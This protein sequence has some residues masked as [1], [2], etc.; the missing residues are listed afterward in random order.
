MLRR[1]NRAYKDGSASA[2]S[3]VAK[4]KR[5]TLHRTL[6]RW[7]DHLGK[8]QTLILRSDLIFE[9]KTHS[10][11]FTE[12]LAAWRKTQADTGTAEKARAFFV[13]RLAIRV[14]RERLAVKRQSAAIERRRL[15]DLKIVFDGELVALSTVNAETKS[16]WRQMTRQ[17]QVDTQIVDG[18]Q[19]AQDKVCFSRI[20][21]SRSEQ[22]QRLL[23]VTLSHWTDRII[24]I[25]SRELDIAEKRKTSLLKLVRP[26]ISWSMLMEPK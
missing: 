16:A 2:E 19:R 4:M 9:T 5:S 7:R 8:H 24:E 17:A 1:T 14:W 6:S 21:S 25:K 26:M 3:F 23:S 10:R 15:S 11:T 13:Q 20:R 18:F 12:W 22:S